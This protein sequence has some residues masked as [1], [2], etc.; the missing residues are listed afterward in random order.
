MV[1]SLYWQGVGEV[2][3]TNLGT[4]ELIELLSLPQQQSRCSFCRVQL[5]TSLR[6]VG[7]HRGR[8]LYNRSLYIS[9]LFS[10]L[11]CYRDWYS[12]NLGTS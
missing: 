11:C 8:R 6:I 1:D 3:C 4:S 7:T 9:S 2:V 5:V 12:R 10:P